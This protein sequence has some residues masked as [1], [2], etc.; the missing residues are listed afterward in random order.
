MAKM[1]MHAA[2]APRLGDDHRPLHRRDAGRPFVAEDLGDQTAVIAVRGQRPQHDT[3]R[4]RAGILRRVPTSCR[5]RRCSGLLHTMRRA[6]QN[7]AHFWTSHRRQR[8]GARHDSRHGMSG[9]LATPAGPDA[10]AEYATRLTERRQRAAAL[11]RAER[12]IG[13]WRLALFGGG[14]VVAVLAFDLRVLSPAWLLVPLLA[15]VALVLAHGRVIPARRRADR[16][17]RYYERGLARPADPWAG[18]GSAGERFA[19]AA[20]PYSGDLDLFG[21]GS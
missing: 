11:A 3:V 1:D 15:F 20:H 14:A 9:A 2:H 12:R 6:Y 18:G 17:V 8:R 10:A 7:R 21:R 5:V 19:D 16:A 13:T 4:E